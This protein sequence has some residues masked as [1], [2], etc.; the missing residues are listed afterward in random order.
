[1][2]AAS[3][4]P[5]WRRHVLLREARQHLVTHRDVIDRRRHGNRRLLHVVLDDALVGVEVGVPGVAVVFHRILAATDAGQPRR[6]ERGAVSPAGIPAARRGCAIDAEV[7]ELR[8]VLA[9]NTRRLWRAK[10]KSST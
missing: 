7:F 10:D 1:M 3:S 9:E 6:I 2:S 8:E 5:R 4:A